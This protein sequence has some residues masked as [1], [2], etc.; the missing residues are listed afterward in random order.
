MARA[1]TFYST[2]VGKKVVMA[3]TGVL[4]VLFLIGHMLGNLQIF[5]GAE[6]LN[7]Y[8]HFLKSTGELLWG[9]RIVMLAAILLH[10]L[11]AVQITLAN[12]KARPVG[13]AMKKD[14]ETGYAARTMIVSGPL[15]LLYVIY[16]LMMFTFLQTPQGLSHTDV[17]GNVVKAFQQPGISAVYIV[18]MLVLGFH[19]YHG[20]WSMLQTLGINHPKLNRLRRI[21]SAVLA[22]LLAAG[23]ISIPV[24][25]LLGIVH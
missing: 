11:A 21:A 6:R 14:I 19:L 7:A 23:Y 22:I 12:W 20:I 15:I 1:M 13:Y 17:Y 25:V 10:I 18:A 16:H 2:T 9:V 3:A 24:S 5:I 4:L 8:A